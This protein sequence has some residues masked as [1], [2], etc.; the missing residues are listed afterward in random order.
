MGCPLA[1]LRAK[2]FQFKVHLQEGLGLKDFIRVSDLRFG[3]WGM[4]SGLE[5]G[6]DVWRFMGP[7][8]WRYFGLTAASCTRRKL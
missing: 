6:W 5:L 2:S 3:N 1:V 8:K 4:G 7:T